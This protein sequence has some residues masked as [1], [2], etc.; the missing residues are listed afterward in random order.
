MIIYNV[1]VNLHDSVHEDW[2]IWNKEIYIPQM[3]AKGG[4]ERARMV[5]VIAEQNSENTYSIQFEAANQE[6]LNQFKKN[7]SH[8]FDA[9][10]LNKYGELMLTFKTELE[11]IS[12][13]K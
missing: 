11:F 7:H 1:T 8:D 5:K 3:I 12:D 2:L 13:F 10:A 6:I 9:L 4:F